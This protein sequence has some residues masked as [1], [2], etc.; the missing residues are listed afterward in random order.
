MPVIPRIEKRRVIYLDNAATTY[1]KPPSVCRAVREAMTRYGGN[2]GRSGHWLA[3]R[4]SEEIFRVREE[5]AALL[6]REEAENTVFTLNATYALN[7]AIKSRV[8]HGSHILL[9]D[10][11]HNAVRR[12]IERLAA[13]GEITRTVVPTGGDFLSSLLDAVKENTRL[14]VCSLAC[15]I[16]GD[17]VPL[18]LLSEFRQ[19]TGIPVIVDAAQA[20]GHMDLDL[21][22]Y[23]VD[24]LCAPAHK[25]LFGIMGAGFAFF[26]DPTVPGTW[27]EG[28]SGSESARA[29][30]PQA[31]PERLEAGTLPTPA[32]LAL[33]AGIRYVRALGTASIAAHIHTLT[34]ELCDNLAGM[35][36]YSMPAPPGHGVLS[37]LHNKYTPARLAA[38]LDEK[39]GI[40]T[41]AGLHCAP[42]PHHKYG[43]LSEGGTLRISFSVMNT[44]EDVRRLTD[45]LY[46]IDR[47]E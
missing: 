12:P 21:S 1:P 4:T 23:P 45:A 38:S 31:L 34:R 44:R 6:H 3:L 36:H 15:N 40:A 19:R 13:T 41:R 9:S 37:L 43:T 8:E 16:S 30:M 28:G 33:G 39:F 18:S 10:I 11:E 17:E 29:E 22:R 35:P 5:V 26:T 7:M 25:G 27:A 2:P 14:L 46:R 47:G 20:A 24:V 42:L 32:I